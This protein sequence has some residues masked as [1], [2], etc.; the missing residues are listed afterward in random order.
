MGIGIEAV[1]G[2]FV[3]WALMLSGSWIRWRMFLYYGDR[4][5]C[6]PNDDM[7]HLACKGPQFENSY[8]FIS[9][10]CWFSTNRQIALLVQTQ[11]HDSDFVV[12][13]LEA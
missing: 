4:A 11:D 13:E 5:S 3:L 12:G 9:L 8:P 1:V 2:G 7:I 6:G 10:F